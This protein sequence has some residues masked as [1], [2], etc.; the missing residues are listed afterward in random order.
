MNEIIKSI[1][2]FFYKREPLQIPPRVDISAIAYQKTARQ[3]EQAFIQVTGHAQEQ[4]PTN[5][6]Q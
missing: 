2:A 6:P 1:P 4:K 5:R 3:F